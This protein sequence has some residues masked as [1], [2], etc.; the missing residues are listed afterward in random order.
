VNWWDRM[1]GAF[2][3]EKALRNQAARGALVGRKKKG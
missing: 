2:A 3:P 1:V